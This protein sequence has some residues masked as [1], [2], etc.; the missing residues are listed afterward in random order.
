MTG[1]IYYGSRSCITFIPAF[2][3][4][5][6]TFKPIFTNIALREILVL[7]VSEA[8]RRALWGS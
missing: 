3:A 8:V 6:S 4:L 7:V 2:R 5:V 1:S